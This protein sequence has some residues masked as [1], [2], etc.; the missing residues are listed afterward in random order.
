MLEALRALFYAALKGLA[1]S[2]EKLLSNQNPE[3]NNNW[4]VQLRQNTS[5]QESL[6]KVRRPA[7]AQDVPM[8]QKKAQH[9]NCRMDT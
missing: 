3:P 1:V 2:F 8:G 7:L 4:V 6:S 5:E 9:K